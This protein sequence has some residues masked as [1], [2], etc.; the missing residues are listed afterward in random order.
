MLTMACAQ[1]QRVPVNF[2]VLHVVPPNLAKL[3]PPL[4]RGSKNIALYVTEEQSDIPIE[5]ALATRETYNALIASSEWARKLL[6]PVRER[7]PPIVTLH[8]GV[9]DALWFPRPRKQVFDK[10]RFVV[11]SGGMLEY[12]KGQDLVVHAF[13]DLVTEHPELKPLLVVW[14]PSRPGT[15]GGL[16]LTGH[17]TGLPEFTPDGKPML[18]KWLV[19]VNGLPE[20]SV[21]VIDVDATLPQIAEWMPEFDA[22]V[23]PA[24]G[25][26]TA[27][28]LV[29]GCMASGVP[30]L[31]SANT[32]NLDLVHMTM[33]K[34][35]KVPWTRHPGNY[36]IRHAYVL[37]KKLIITSTQ[38]RVCARARRGRRLTTEPAQTSPAGARFGRGRSATSCCAFTASCRRAPRRTRPRRPCSTC[39]T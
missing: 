33:L 35:V 28:V 2:P 39:R 16:D 36:G 29:T 31:V 38:E 17:V 20:D 26:G 5:N 32:A 14:W 25:E 11:F 30:T 12:H 7:L 18:K 9:D 3:A 23:F 21:Y 24:R 34:N 19:E 6:D 22:C 4:F 15:V 1:G 10:S 8:H 37:W 27:D 13:K